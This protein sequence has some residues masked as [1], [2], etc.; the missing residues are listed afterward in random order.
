MKLTCKKTMVGIKIYKTRRLL[1]MCRLAFFCLNRA[2]SL[3]NLL[4][5]LMKG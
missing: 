4:S 2:K 1:M 3:A 5:H